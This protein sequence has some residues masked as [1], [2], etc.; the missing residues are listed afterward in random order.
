MD[1]NWSSLSLIAR[2]LD[3]VK[4]NIS[5]MRLFRSYQSSSTSMSSN[6]LARDS[7]KMS[8]TASGPAPSSGSVRTLV[9]VRL[10]R[11]INHTCADEDRT[12]FEI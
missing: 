7:L 4:G 2:F 3:L 12:I 11:L 8:P 9:I 6:K 10:A 1:S 5:A